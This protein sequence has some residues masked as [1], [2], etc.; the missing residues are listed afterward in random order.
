MSTDDL[1]GIALYGYDPVS[2]FM[3][4]VPKAGRADFEYSWGGAVWRFASAANR[5]AF[6]AEPQ[7]YAPLFDGYDASAVAEGRIVESDPQSFA[8]LGGRL[9]FFHTKASRLAFLSNEGLRVRSERAWPD[10][11]R[12]LAR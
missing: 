8:I 2:Y 4:G 12:Q 1:S 11:V 10:T 5:Q 3:N 7:V 9:Y 6:I